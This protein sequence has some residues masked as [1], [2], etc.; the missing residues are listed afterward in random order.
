MNSKILNKRKAWLNQTAA[1]SLDKWSKEADKLHDFEG[2]LK[3]FGI[4]QSVNGFDIN[5]LDEN[6]CFRQ[7]LDLF[8]VVLQKQI[9]RENIGIPCLEKPPAY[10][11]LITIVG[12]SPEPLMHTVLVLAPKKVY[13]VATIESASHY[14]VPL[15]PETRKPDGSILYF[16][17]ILEHYKEPSQT[18]TVEPIGRNV[19]S[20]GSLDTFKRVR[21]IINEV[22]TNNPNAKIALDITGGKKSADVSAFLTAA[23]EKNIDIYYIDFEDYAGTKACCG[24][25]FLNKLDNPYEIYNVQL[26]NQAKELF[27]NH[28]YQAAYQLFSEIEKRLSPDGLEKPA[29]YDLEDERSIVI[30]MKK[31]A[32]CYMY[33]DRYSYS[34]ALSASEILPVLQKK[35][36]ERL[37]QYD[38]LG[39]K[40]SKYV[41]DLF[42]DYVLDRYIS[43]ERRGIH[44]A[45]ED[46]GGYHDAILRYYQ[47]VEMMLDAFITNNQKN[48]FYDPDKDKYPTKIIR[49]LCFNGFAE[50]GRSEKIRIELLK[51]ITDS[52]LQTKIS[53]LNNWRDGFVHIKGSVQKSNIINAKNIVIQLIKLY[54]DNKQSTEIDNDLLRY[55]FCKSF[56]GDGFLSK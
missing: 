8:K 12:F 13:P 39:N 44:I 42:Y 36:L 25:E 30:R 40:K 48:N 20:I 4:K 21:K 37:K 11:A 41:S 53:N 18:I 38:E 32:E 35:H 6:Y 46:L 15:T 29:K 54:F 47:C 5:S 3:Y 28:D 55:N 19:A 45:D 17:T 2:T 10:D 43:A 9:T 31:A 1:Q 33:W 52:S 16:E 27:M 49:K 24:T 22:R 56:S 34:H 51:K 7:S 23:I 14:K 50:I 26:L